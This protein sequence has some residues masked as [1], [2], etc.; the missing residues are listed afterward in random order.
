MF[1]IHGNN[2][3]MLLSAIKSIKKYHKKRYSDTAR[4]A[5]LLVLDVWLLSSSNQRFYRFH[6]LQ[7]IRKPQFPA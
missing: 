2:D 5:G 1:F 3:F 4:V 6:I 7:K